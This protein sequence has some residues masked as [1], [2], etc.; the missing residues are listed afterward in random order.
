MM[1]RRKPLQN[2]LF[3]PPKD[4]GAR[5]PPD[6]LLRKVNKAV[7]FDFSYDAVSDFYG[8][9]GKESIPP[10]TILRLLRFEPQFDSLDHG[11]LFGNAVA[12]GNDVEPAF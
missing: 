1:S 6:H 5:V 3:E 4:L 2:G 8:A 7:D 9:V 11:V 12:G 10:P